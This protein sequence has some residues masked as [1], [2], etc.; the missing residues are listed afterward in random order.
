MKP[1][2]GE[3]LAAIGAQAGLRRAR[4]TWQGARRRRG[5]ARRATSLPPSSVVGKGR[6]RRPRRRQGRTRLVRPN[7][8]VLEGEMSEVSDAIEAAN[9]ARHRRSSGRRSFSDIATWRRPGA[10]SVLALIAI[11]GA[12]LVAQAAGRDDRRPSRLSD[13]DLDVAS[14]HRRHR[15][16]R[17]PRPGARRV[18]RALRNRGELTGDAA[19]TREQQ[20]HASSARRAQQRDRR[21]WSARRSRAISSRRVAAEFA[22]QEL[23]T[24]GQSVNELVETVDRGDRRDRRRCSRRWPRPT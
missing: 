4:P 21:A 9:V 11:C 2:G 10:S 12:A 13:G 16:D 23:N 14:I 22:D 17:R 1:Y 6:R 7:F 19:A 24:L 18:P 3:F 20:R 5:A 15:R 8:E